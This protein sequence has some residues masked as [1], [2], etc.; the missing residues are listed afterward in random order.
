MR[1]T[2]TA[3]H[4][5]IPEAL[6][7][8]ARARLERL[9]RVAPRPHDVRLIFAAEHGKPMVELRMHTNRRTVY[10]ATA[11]DSDHRSAFDR[12]V[13]KVR[14]QLDKPPA[15]RRRAARRETQ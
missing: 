15:R 5:D 7:E 8:R 2:I 10:V 11:S 1:I 9:G 13:A 12:V 4:C 14:R 6:Q 3:R